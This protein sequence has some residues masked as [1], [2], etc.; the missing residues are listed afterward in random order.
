[1]SRHGLDWISGLLEAME[2]TGE[3]SGHVQTCLV[4]SAVRGDGECR[5]NIHD[6]S[7]VRGDGD[8]GEIL[9]LL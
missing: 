4:M 3:I 6:M 8:T 5:R 1:M 2:N 7:T 9:G